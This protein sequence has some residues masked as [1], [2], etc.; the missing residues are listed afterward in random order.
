MPSK[1]SRCIRRFL[2]PGL[3]FSL[4]TIA[5]AQQPI[6][7]PNVPPPGQID[8]PPGRGF[9][10]PR[11][12]L[13]HLTAKDQMP[14]LAAAV[15]AAWDWRQEGKVTAVRY[16]GACGA[17]YAFAAL[18]N[19]EARMLIDA[20]GTFD[21]SENN[22]KECNYWQT[23]CSG[24][25]YENVV[26]LLS[27][28]AT[29]LES[30]DPYVAGDVACNSACTYQKTLLNWNII[31][32]ETV[33]STA[34][35]KQLIYDHGPI[36]TT[37]YSGDASDADWQNEF[38]TYNGSYTLYYTGNY[39]TNHAVLIVGWDDGLVHAGGT[40][41]WIVKNSWGTS[42]GGPCGYGVS[43]GYF[44][45]AYGSAG[46]GQWSSYMDQWQDYS[47]N[48]DIYFYDEG[49]WTSQWGYGNTTVWGMAKFVITQNHYVT[50]V[51]FWTND[52]TTD[53]DVYLYD[54]FNGSALSNLLATSLDNSFSEAGYHSV[55]FSSPPEVS[56]GEDVYAVV[57][58][59]NST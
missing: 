7:A 23:S 26:D 19:I 33:P 31:S 12:D 51:E 56:A 24:G 9:V 54:S 30:C 45:I 32:S 10:P 20:A 35:L 28:S 4:C 42:W 17:C 36:Y 3:L 55:R 48:D 25:N 41:G 46:I 50:R 38:D 58:L 29:V 13:S 59:T 43:G 18:G 27:K 11:V 5:F 49:G 8:M 1:I 34:A 22:A 2:I 37:L 39:E 52:A 40:G 53:V 14:G 57:K 15:P 6:M 16:Q 21:F 44:T 47:P